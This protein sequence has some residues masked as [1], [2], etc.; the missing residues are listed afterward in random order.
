MYICTILQIF[1][2]R[3][4]LLHRVHNDLKGMKVLGIL[5]CG[6][7]IQ[8]RLDLRIA[9]HT[10]QLKCIYWKVFWSDKTFFRGLNHKNHIIEL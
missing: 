3:T 7:T 6:K 2:G 1:W 4:V 9:E 8:K 5:I 10:F